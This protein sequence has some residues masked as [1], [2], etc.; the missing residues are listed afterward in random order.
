MLSLKLVKLKKHSKL[1]TAKKPTDWGHLGTFNP[2]KPWMIW[3]NCAFCTI[4]QAVNHND[5]HQVRRRLFRG[6]LICAKCL[7]TIRTMIPQLKELGYLK[8]KKPK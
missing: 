2:E 3:E 8:M 1:P 6:H 7:T 5:L 4:P